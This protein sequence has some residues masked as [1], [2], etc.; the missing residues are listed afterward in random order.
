MNISNLSSLQEK[1]KIDPSAFPYNQPELLEQYRG[2][3]IIV[4]DDQIVAAGDVDYRPIFQHYRSLGKEPI[5][6]CIPAN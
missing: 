5:I 6:I 3:N 1:L 4:V 2:H